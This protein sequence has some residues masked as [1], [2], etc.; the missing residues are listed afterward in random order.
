MDK[1]VA[2]LECP[3][4]LT[5]KDKLKWKISAK[6]RLNKF[7]QAISLI[8]EGDTVL[9]I[10][11]SPSL[12]YTTNY[13]E[14]Y[15]NLPNKL[16]CLGVLGGD[17]NKFKEAFPNF[18]LILFDGVTFP[19]FEEKF[20]FAFSNAVIEHVGPFETQ[21]KW[22]K[23]LSK[24]TKILT[25]T[26]PNKWFPFETHTH[27]FFFH[28]LPLNMR[29]FIYK[30]IGKGHFTKD[31]MWLLSENAFRKILTDA[32]LEIIH[33]YKNKVLF[34]TLDFFAVCKPITNRNEQNY[35]L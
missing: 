23:E 15:Y 34:F 7:R 25:I 2:L 13:F 30:K 29:N 18:D 31:Y 26:T 35:N 4:A 20:D 5:L 19:H 3:D 6:N 22:V 11:V 1:E 28:W 16:T 12:A 14:K 17:F 24:I 21:V 33:L 9:D 10:G 32:G 8:R 27:T